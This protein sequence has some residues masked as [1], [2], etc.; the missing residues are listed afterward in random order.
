MNCL[1]AS[2]P[3]LVA[4][5]VTAQVD[6]VERRPAGR[7]TARSQHALAAD[8]SRG[9]V[10]L[11]GGTT[12]SGALDDTWVWDGNTW[13]PR[14]PSS[15]PSARS[16]HAMTYDARRGVVVLFGGGTFL[17]DTWEWNGASWARVATTGPAGRTGHAMAYD[18]VRARVVL[19]GGFLGP[20]LG[21]ASDTWEWDGRAWTQRT[22][23][24]LPPARQDHAL[25]FDGT[26]I[27]LF[28]G[29]LSSTFFNATWRYDGNDWRML[30]PIVS[31][32]GRFDH[33]MTY[34]P[35][36]RR[37]VLFGGATNA[38]LFGT[39]ETWEWDGANWTDRNPTSR[40]SARRAHAIAWD[41]RTQ[42][43]VAFGGT[44]LGSLDDTHDY[45]PHTHAEVT[46]F[47][48]GCPGS[49]G[50]PLLETPTDADLP[51]IGEK[52]SVVVRNVPAG[53]NNAFGLLGF[54]STDWN[55]VPLPLDLVV[56]GMPGCWL[57]TSIDATLSLN[58][59]SGTATGS[60]QIPARASLI[61]HAF[62]YQAFVLDPPVIATVSNA[63]KAGIGSK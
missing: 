56:L 18:A 28:G 38:A 4:A 36:R 62:Y 11:F 14:S 42:R 50:V 15:R 40:P 54:S 48:T 34:D 16:G 22:T 51:W 2:L 33:A 27:V 12:P 52:F 59:S 47:G 10:V 53:T 43:T 29:A 8:L 45:G 26:G 19:F 30:A 41:R 25:A 46:P 39:D 23:A 55:G 37:A 35:L 6:W 57:Q 58:S 13:A 63:L 61:G 9:Q 49:A 20:T 60:V 1:P 44:L 17:G 32:A 21:W 31:P 3:L 5:A 24:T 7:P